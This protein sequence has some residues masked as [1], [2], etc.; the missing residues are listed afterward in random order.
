MKTYTIQYWENDRSK[1]F[2]LTEISELKKEIGF[3]VWFR[4]KGHKN[5]QERLK[6]GKLNG[7]VKAWLWNKYKDFTNYKK[8]KTQGIQ[9]IFKP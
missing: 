3:A 4:K 9:I 5:T 7:L 1:P 2:F 8:E 6:N